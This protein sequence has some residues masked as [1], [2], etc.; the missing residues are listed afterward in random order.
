MNL[1]EKEER[2]EKRKKGKE[3]SQFS[4]RRIKDHKKLLNIVKQLVE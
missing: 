1:V 3:S 4:Q 2:N